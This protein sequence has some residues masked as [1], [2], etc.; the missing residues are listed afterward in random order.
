[1]AARPPAPLGPRGGPHHLV[2]ADAADTSP[3]WAQLASRPPRC[4]RHYSLWNTHLAANRTRRARGQA[5]RDWDP[6]EP[7]PDEKHFLLLDHDDLGYLIEDVL[8]DMDTHRADMTYARNTTQYRDAAEALAAACASLRQ[9][10]LRDLR[11]HERH[12]QGRPPAPG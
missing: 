5:E 7:T 9:W 10:L 6:G 11:A 4:L 3:H 8:G 1:M 2:C 12:R